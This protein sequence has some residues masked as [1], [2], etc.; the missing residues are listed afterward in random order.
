MDEDFVQVTLGSSNTF[1][2][3]EVGL[4]RFEH[5][6]LKDVCSVATGYT[7]REFE[8]AESHLLRVSN[9]V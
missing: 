9:F 7:Q 2:E 1:F 3:F 8:F 5:V 4:L 6:T